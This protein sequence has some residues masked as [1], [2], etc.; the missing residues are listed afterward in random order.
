MILGSDKLSYHT[1]EDRLLGVPALT[2]MNRQITL[3][4]SGG[5]SEE[6]VDEWI[7][8]TR[9]YAG[10]TDAIVRQEAMS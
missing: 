1:L 10:E 7:A 3:M 6:K 4:R 5:A 9:V 8:L 2:Y